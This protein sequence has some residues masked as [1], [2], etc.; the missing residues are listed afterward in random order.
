MAA[1]V[2]NSQGQVRRNARSVSGDAT[3][4]IMAA[5]TMRLPMTFS[6]PDGALKRGSRSSTPPI[7]RNVMARAAPANERVTRTARARVEY[8]HFGAESPVRG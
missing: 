1:A 7:P 4:K 5:T 6:R 2:A 3:S 8:S